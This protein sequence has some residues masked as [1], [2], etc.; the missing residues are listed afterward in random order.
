[1]FKRYFRRF[2][3]RGAVFLT[4]LYFYLFHYD[5]FLELLYT[6][7]LGPAAPIHALWVIFMTI[8]VVHL[9]PN[10]RITMAARKSLGLHFVPAE[11]Y[12]KE[13]LFDFVSDQ[14][15]RAWRV[16]LAWICFNAVWGVLFLSGVIGQEELLMLTVFYYLSD[17]ICLLFFC[18]FQRFFM[19]NRCCVNCRIFDWGH[20]MMFTPLVFIRS[21]FTWSLFFMSVVVLIR[22]ELIYAKHPERF[23]AGS[24]T[25][26]RCENCHD[27]ICKVKKPLLARDK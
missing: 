10:W 9:L 7:L 17:F 21:F 8:M 5:W 4:V 14:N 18:P 1:M 15:I 6:P 20:F 3:L 25:T 13:E 12:S 22:W 27:K 2:L 26:L 24:N 19:K 23:W 16:M 11:N